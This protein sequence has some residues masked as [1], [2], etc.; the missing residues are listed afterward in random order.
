MSRRGA[1]SRDWAGR[2][3]IALSCPIVVEYANHGVAGEIELPEAWRVALDDP[4]PTDA[5]YDWDRLCR[6][7]AAQEPQ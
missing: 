6:A 1:V 4:L 3:V 5:F 7:L 2:S